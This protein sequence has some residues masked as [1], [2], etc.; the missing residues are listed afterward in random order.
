MLSAKTASGFALTILSLSVFFVSTSFA[1]TTNESA[2]NESVL[3]AALATNA[4]VGTGSYS[5]SYSMETPP[6]EIA[7]APGKFEFSA[8]SLKFN[9]KITYET[10]HGYRETAEIKVMFLNEPTFEAV[11][12]DGGVKQLKATFKVMRDDKRTMDLDIFIDADGAV[13]RITASDMVAYLN[14]KPPRSEEIFTCR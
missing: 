7:P 6:I 9:R 10:D 13:K 1:S 3:R 12:F 8:L 2:T 14:G 5:C 4:Q 11:F